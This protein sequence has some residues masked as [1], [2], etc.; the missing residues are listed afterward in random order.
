MRKFLIRIS[1]LLA[2]AMATLAIG[3]AATGLAAYYYLQPGLPSAN[4]I[5]DVQLQIP[6]R[7]YARD[8]RLIA[9]LGEKRRTPVEFK[10]IPEG[11]YEI[12]VQADG[13]KTTVKVKVDR[14]R[15]VGRVILQ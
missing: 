12:E 6:L 8:G 15:A 13:K 9:Q 3:T 14:S 2:G 5:R 1:P 4:T 10:D 11:T 7:I